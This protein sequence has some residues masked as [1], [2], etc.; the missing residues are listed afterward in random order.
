MDDA[1]SDDLKRN[2]ALPRKA[3]ALEKSFKK[4][5]PQIPFE[6]DFQWAGVFA[7]TK[8]GLLYI[9]SIPERPHTYFAL[10]FGGNG[11][12]FSMVAAHLLRD[13]FCSRKNPDSQIYSFDR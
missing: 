1:F 2:A 4:L 12:T 8:N 13:S 6:T 9:G 7:A 11:V 5:F 10:G 3:K